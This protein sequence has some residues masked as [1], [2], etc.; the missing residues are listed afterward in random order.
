V[1]AV[2]LIPAPAADA[3]AFRQQRFR[4]FATMTVVLAP[5]YLLLNGIPMV[6]MSGHRPD[7]FQFEVTVTAVFT[8][9]EP[10]AGGLVVALILG[11]R[12]GWVRA[13][14]AGLEFGGTGQAPAFLPWPAVESVGVRFRGPFTQL[15]VTPTHPD[16]AAVAS[17]RG[18]APRLRRRF[19]GPAG[20]YVVDVGLMTPRPLVLLAELNRR[21]A[22]R[23]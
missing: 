3:V 18:R 19:G 10:L 20:A 13:S 7:V 2:D 9:L 6:V 21:L 17:V 12:L 5:V 23:G 4:L 22:T 8:V 14:T 1:S 16:A 15:L 11:R